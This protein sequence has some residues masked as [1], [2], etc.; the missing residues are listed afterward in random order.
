[1]VASVASVQWSNWENLEANAPRTIQLSF[2]GIAVRVPTIAQG[3]KANM[4]LLWWTT[5]NAVRKLLLIT[6]FVLS[7]FR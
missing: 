1:M 4:I 3:I 7:R 6:Y 2:V 5:P